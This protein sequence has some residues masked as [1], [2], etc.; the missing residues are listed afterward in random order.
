[1]N[2]F[3][4]RAD[5]HSQNAPAWLTI[6]VGYQLLGTPRTEPDG[7]SLAHPVL[8]SDD[9]RRSGPPGREGAPLVAEATV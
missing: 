7:R 3:H 1:M 2:W 5:D 9:W 8:I 4:K 6:A